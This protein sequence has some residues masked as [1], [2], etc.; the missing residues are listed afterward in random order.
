MGGV[1]VTQDVI[2]DCLEIDPNDP[3]DFERDFV[4]GIV[5]DDEQPENK[6]QYAQGFK[7]GKNPDYPDG[8]IS[9]RRVM[10]YFTTKSGKK[11]PFAQKTQRAGDGPSSKI[12][13]T[14]LW[15]EQS[16]ECF[17]SHPSNKEE[18]K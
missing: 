4:V 14:Y 9:G 8:L 17:K 11:V 5:G 7:P 18:G 12:R 2:N 13:S 16:Q 15:S 6:Y 3:L 10:V 1:V